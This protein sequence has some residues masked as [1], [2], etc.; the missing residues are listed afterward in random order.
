MPNLLAGKEVVP[1]FIQHRAEPGA[2]A[3]AVRVLMENA[4]ARERMISEFDAMIRGVGD[5][6]AGKRAA[7]AI[8]EELEEGRSP[9]RLGGLETAAP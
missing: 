9:D 3:K 1:E 6:G 5:T 4:Q 8:I 2:L 7:Q